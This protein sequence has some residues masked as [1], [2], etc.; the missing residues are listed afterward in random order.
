MSESTNIA[1]LELSIKSSSQGADKSLDALANSLQRLK[2]ATKGGL[3]LTAVAKQLTTVRTAV[4]GIGSSASSLNSLATAI[5]LLSGV[6]ISTTIGKQI[7]SISTALKDAN[8]TGGSQKIQ[9][10][11]T[12]LQPLS[13]LPKTNMTGYVNSIKK[14][15]EVLNSID[16]NTIS[17][18]SSKIRQLADALRPLGTEMQKVANGFSA[19]PNKLQKLIATTDRYSL[20]NTRARGSAINLF[21]KLTMGIMVFKRVASAIAGAIKNINTHIE[22]I[23]LFTASMGKYADEAKRYAETVSEIMGID[24]S[25]WLRNQGVFMTL[26]TGFGVVGDRAN[27]MSQQLTQLGYDISSFFN[28]SFSDAMLKLQSGVSGELEPLRRLGYDLSEARLKAVALELGIGKAVKQMTQAEKAELRYYA[29]MNQVTTAHG[30]M[31]RTLHA[32]ANQLRILQ[33]QVTQAGRAIGSIFIPALNAVLPYAIAFVQAIREMASAVAS[34]FGF[35]MPEVDYSGLDTVVGGAEDASNALDNASESA[36]KLKSYMLGFDELNVINPN[37]GSG[38]GSGATGG[39]SGFEFELPEYDFLADATKGRVEKIMKSLEPAI[40]FVKDNFKEILTIVTAIG[41]GIIAWKMIDLPASLISAIKTGGL[42]KVKL[43]L[44]FLITGVTLGL[45]NGYN[46]GKDGLTFKNFLIQAISN[47]LVIGGSLL[48]FG[49]GPAGWIV[50]I[51][52]ALLMNIGSI[53]WGKWDKAKLEDITDRFGKYELSEEEIAEWTSNITSTDLGLK[54]NLYV[55]EVEKVSGLKEQIETAIATLNGYNFKISCG[56]TVEKETYELTLDEVITTAQSYISQKQV[57][58]VIAL[59][60]LFD[61]SETGVR[62]TEFVNT[63]YTEQNSKLNELGKEL[64]Q[65]VSEGFVEGEWIPEKLERAIEL[66]KEIQSILDYISTV[67]FTAKLEALKLEAGGVDITPESFNNLMASANEVVAEG[68][69]NLEGVRLE[70]LKIAK[71]EYDNASLEEKAN[72]TAQQLYDKAVQEAQ[73]QFLLGRIE[74]MYGTFDFGLDTIT[75]AYGTEVES[76]VPLLAQSTE[77]LVRQG[78]LFVLPEET[79]TDID[80]MYGNMHDALVDGFMNAEITN[81]GRANIEELLKTLEPT[82]KELSDLCDEYIKTGKNVPDS[83]AKGLN[84]IAMLKALS[85]NVESINYLIGQKLSTD[86]TFIDL[87]GTSEDA[88]AK[89][90]ENVGKGLLAN[91]KIIE[92]NANGTITLIND[93]IGTKVFEVTP[94]LVKNLSDLGANLSEGLLEGVD[95]NI[96]EK[97][98]VSVWE[99]IGNWFANLFDINSPSVVFMEYGGFLSEGLLKGVDGGVVEKDYTS[100][101]DRIPEALK[102][103]T[104]PIKNIVNGIIATFET[105]ANGVIKGINGLIRGLNKISFDIPEWVPVLGGKSFSINIPTV[106]TI[107]IPRLMAD[108]GY[109]DRGQM[110]IARERGAEMVGAIGNRTAVANNDQIVSGIAHGVAEANNEQN[111]LLREQNNLLRALLE[112]ETGVYLDGKSLTNSVEKYQRERGR[113]LISGGAYGG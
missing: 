113:V 5:R 13:A 42:D 106:P 20:S 64:K 52:V 4:A 75:E 58:G 62:L 89:V 63:F 73:E 16:A 59:D 107:S 65:V 76:I 55:E 102:K 46:I 100:I 22:N 25:E 41:S 44:T 32:P 33:A 60:I 96:V 56:L 109:V 38:G 112:K 37:E 87:L 51:S 2:S 53:A 24:P 79:Y 29:I 36:K 12:V 74:L 30:D 43:G 77:E 95:E 91:T 7:T 10:L 3:G 39:G 103:I 54:V 92:D 84:D 14:L 93:T 19:F 47:A 94:T 26:L 1:S 15:P 11:V 104:Q 67:E 101:F 71:M 31:A 21:A 78:H 85:G 68:L 8:F 70:A 111:S 69:A 80:V 105:M 34:F 81:A 108:G 23:N 82:E 97:D 88:G 6:K 90:G 72:G 99:R 57:T 48:T 40:K 45:A 61:S 83:V 18:V 50:G 9:E 49:T 66:E 98:Y 28:I 86:S 35:E 17:Q 110:F 27:K